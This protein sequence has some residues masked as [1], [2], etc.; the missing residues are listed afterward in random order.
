MGEGAI[1]NRNFGILWTGQFLVTAGLTVVVPLLPFYLEQLGAVSTET[2]MLWS[3]LSL[4]APAIPLTLAAPFWGRLGDRYGRKLMVVRA[5]FGIAFSMILMSRARTPLQFFIARLLQGAFG[6]IDNAAATFASTQTSQEIRGKIMG[7]LQTATAAGALIGPL[8]GGLLSDRYGFSPL[9]L[10]IGVLIGV[11]GLCAAWG[12]REK[13]AS[14][15]AIA[16]TAPLRTVACNLLGRHEA[17]SF[18][19]AGLCAQVGSYGIVT[20]FAIH[21]REMLTDPGHAAGWVGSLQAVTL[22]AT[23]IGAAWWGRH[24]DRHPLKRNFVIASIG[25]ALSVALLSLPSQAGWLFPLRFIQGFCMSAIGQSVYLRVSCGHTA[26][27]QGVRIGL[28]NSFLTLGQVIGSLTGGILSAHVSPEWVFISMGGFYTL[29]AVLVLP[30]RNPDGE[31]SKCFRLEG[32]KT[33]P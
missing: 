28:A 16:A 5:L 25:C 13:K 33:I 32:G 31:Q 3:G 20:I 1:W 26:E 6:G 7:G 2:N 8:A 14:S 27:H 11:G 24:N 17:L 12:M 18:V 22:T 21:V 30:A 19:L 29:G 4:A 23:L 15:Q 10:S 9:I